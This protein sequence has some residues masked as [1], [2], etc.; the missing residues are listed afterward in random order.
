MHEHR[1]PKLPINCDPN[2]DADELRAAMKGLG[3]VRHLIVLDSL[4]RNIDILVL[5]YLL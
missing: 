2:R 1:P 4:Y 3:T 5:N